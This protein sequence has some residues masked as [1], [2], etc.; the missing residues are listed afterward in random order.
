MIVV[1]VIATILCA[2]SYR[3]G[4]MSKEEAKIK[5]PWVPLFLVKGRT[6][7]I[8]CVL[9]V[10]LWVYLFL[11]QVKG[12]LYLYSSIL[13]FL[14]MTTYW[15]RWPPNKGR[16]N[17][18]MHGL[19]IG[20]SLLPIAYGSG[21]WAEVIIR[22]VVLGFLMRVWCSVFSNVDMEEYFRGGIIGA[23]L[24]LLLFTP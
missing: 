5:L 12:I 14:A 8:V 16:D 2:I 19:F 24:P 21:M 1:T 23:T 11:P 13:M 3:A 20:L 17:F 6:R 10:M 22:A 9:V 7:D 4:G 15:D 18:F